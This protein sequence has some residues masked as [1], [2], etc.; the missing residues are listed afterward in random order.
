V[1]EHPQPEEIFDEYALGVLE[2]EERHAF[3][4]HIEACPPCLRKV[5]EARARMAL[6]ALATPQI[7]PPPGAKERLL[8]RV[9]SPSPAPLQQ[10]APFWGW[11]TA[12]LAAATGVLALA[13]LF[14]AARNREL[15]RNL[16]EL[17][18]RQTQLLESE[19]RLGEESARAHAVLDI[20]TSP[21]TVRVYLASTPSRLLP[22]GKAFYHPQKGL[23]F[24]AT[25]LPRL[26]AHRTY[27]LW[28]VPPQGKPVS[29]GVFNTD[30][31]GNGEVLLPSLPLGLPVK[32]F[33]VTVEPA[34]GEPQ[35]TGPK[36]LVGVTS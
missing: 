10:P 27:Q 4:S 22:E 20:L 28:L 19:R 8:R 24:Y 18:A 25:N 34:G 11:T 32:A 29:A 16:R 12:A 14:V 1:N 5:E 30:P 35:P 3:E 33:A 13:L 7:Q 31:Q 6:L 26:P 2:G 9:A 15:L 23:L 17:E 36:V 21:Q